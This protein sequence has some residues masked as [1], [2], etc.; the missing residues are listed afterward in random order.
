[1]LCW[2]FLTIVD[3]MNLFCVNFRMFQTACMVQAVF[4]Y[5][6]PHW[7]TLLLD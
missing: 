2:G 1:M 7:E 4:A 6:T 3:E 5:H